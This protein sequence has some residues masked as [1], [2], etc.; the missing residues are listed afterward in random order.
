MI[1]T[2][3]EI[4]INLF[5]AIL[6]I[7]FVRRK[8]NIVRPELRYAIL[9]AGAIT[10]YLSLY[11][12]FEVPISDTVVFLIPACYAF[13]VSDDKGYIKLFWSIALPV[14]FI[15]MVELTIS[16]FSFFADTSW[17]QIMDET[18]LRISFV[19]SSNLGILITIFLL[20]RHTNQYT[21]SLST[22]IIFVVL[23]IMYLILV[24]MLYSIRLH[25]QGN[26]SLFIAA[27]ICTMLCAILTLLLYE[28]MTSTAEKKQVYESEVRTMRLTQQHAEE[29]RD[30]YSYMIAQQHDLNK[31]YNVVHE[32]LVSG[33]HAES[34]KF[35]SQLPQPKLPDGTFITGCL[36]I[37]ALLTIKKL[38]MDRIGAAF[39]FQPYPLH[40][41]PT[42]ESNFCAILSNLL[43]NAIEAVAQ[44]ADT[45]TE[46]RINLSL[47]R[48]WSIFFITCEN[49]ADPTKIKMTGNQLVSS[50]EHSSHHGYGTRNIRSIVNQLGGS[51]RYEWTGQ[52]FRVEIILPYPEQE[53]K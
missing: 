5:Q 16:F 43:D 7:Y 36:A 29:V 14:V 39:T 21:L 45:H 20:T 9:A 15:G 44:L 3:F 33:H 25:T 8:F 34:Q 27:G 4:A 52:Y 37:D 11:L 38:A 10:A 13:A 6:M 41:L 32:M 23:E 17:Q 24:E 46:R 28:V 47:A 22:I 48:S 42:T 40:T 35:L 49:N 30:M 1:W 53:T 51:Y 19:I 50:K 31:Q 26:D 12:F 2:S 18:P